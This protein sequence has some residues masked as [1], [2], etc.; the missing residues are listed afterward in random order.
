MTGVGSRVE[1]SG[2]TPGETAPEASMTAKASPGRLALLGVQQMLVSNVWLDPIFIASAGALATG[3]GANLIAVTFLAAG[4]IT[5]AQTLR[6]VRLPIVDGPSSAFSPLAIGYAHAGSLASASLGLL[7]GAAIV[8][9]TSVTGLLGA[10]RRAMTPTVTGTIIL[11]VGL[12]LTSFGFAELIGGMGSPD[13]GSTSSLVIAAA[14]VV[15]LVAC[16][17]FARMRSAAFLVALVVGDLVALAYGRLD[18]GPVAEAAWFGVPQLLPYGALTFDL[19]ITI[20][21]CI[22]F[23]VAVIEAMGIYEA[24]AAATGQS[25]PTRRMAGGIAAEAAGSGLAAL[26]GGFGTTAYAQ[27]LG[28][29]KLTGVARLEVIRV[30]A[31]G[32]IL[33]A[34]LPKVAA[35]FAATPAPVVGALLVTAAITVIVHGART[36]FGRG[37][38]VTAACAVAAALSVPGLTA[39]LEWDPVLLQVLSSSVAVGAIVALVVQTA[40]A[41]IGRLQRSRTR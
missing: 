17:V 13:F 41:L 18:F 23:F 37:H 5:L 31:V 27:N 25:L 15:A 14:T 26:F 29:I 21:M 16:I 19:G 40:V 1:E 35:V 30:A 32:F 36:A 39:A 20:T 8:F 11:L 12:S 28:V 38:A 10:V 7:I 4:V 24:T 3:L 33:L 2:Q 34:F 22:I 6:F 9:L